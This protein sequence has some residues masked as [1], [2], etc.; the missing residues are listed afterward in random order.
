[1]PA[2][3]SRT[4]LEAKK[5]AELQSLA[6][7]HNI[8]ANLKTDELV[9]E[10]QKAMEKLKKSGPSTT[11]TTTARRV[12]SASE[13]SSGR[14]R[15]V[16]G[17]SKI[18][19]PSIST[20]SKSVARSKPGGFSV[21]SKGSIV[22]SDEEVPPK[23][24][25]RRQAS[26]KPSNSTTSR[27]AGTSSRTRRTPASVSGG[28]KGKATEKEEQGRP[29]SSKD[30]SASRQSLGSA[31]V[32]VEIPSRRTSVNH[33]G[34]GASPQTTSK[35]LESQS[36]STQGPVASTSQTG[37]QPINRPSIISAPFFA[38]P[39][40]PTT[41]SKS[42]STSTLLETLKGSEEFRGIAL[43]T[44]ASKVAI[45][46]LTESLRLERERT[47]QLREE[48]EAVR[49]G[50]DAALDD[51]K[52]LREDFL[53]FRRVGETSTRQTE[54][55][56]ES[57]K[58]TVHAL[59]AYARGL[60]GR[61]KTLE[62]DKENVEGTLPP[63]APLNLG[64]RDRE[65]TPQR[66]RGDEEIA[67]SPSGQPSPT[68]RAR[69][70]EPSQEEPP[71]QRSVIEE[72]PEESASTDI[73][74]TGEIAPAPA[75]QEEPQTTIAGTNGKPALLSLGRPS[76]PPVV[77]DEPPQS[78]PITAYFSSLVPPPN[79]QHPPS[80][81]IPKESLV[82]LPSSSAE[83]IQPPLSALPF[84]LI[85]SK[86]LTTG[87]SLGSGSNGLKSSRKDGSSGR[88]NPIA[89]R[90]PRGSTAVSKADSSVSPA[91][92]GNTGAVSFGYSVGSPS[93]SSTPRSTGE[94]SSRDDDG[95]N[96]SVTL[97]P[98]K[99]SSAPSLGTLPMPRSNPFR[100]PSFE[101]AP[102]LINTAPSTS[103]TRAS[104]PTSTSNA[105]LSPA[106]SIDNAPRGYDEVGDFGFQEESYMSLDSPPPPSP[107]KR[108]MY[109]TEIHPPIT[110]SSSFGAGATGST[111]GPFSLFGSVARTGTSSISAG[112]AFRGGSLPPFGATGSSSSNGGLP[113]APEPRIAELPP[114]DEDG[115]PERE[116]D[117]AFQQTETTGDGEMRRNPRANYGLDDPL[118][119]GSPKRPSS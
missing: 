23:R 69:T 89:R 93:A 81:Q 7:E 60:E 15:V 59:D 103:P 9:I 115:G 12:P 36:V 94:V 64:K 72:P 41:P 63:P 110:Q 108:T 19:G 86:P 77:N 8:K 11:T 73:N 40:A 20:S 52:T 13:S 92:V 61:V 84:P 16:P 48:L 98:P 85:P 91:N 2:V 107:S 26:A 51:L 17:T 75:T 57:L 43:D 112:N 113:R 33:T 74:P 100:A 39:A 114:V 50:K 88:Y 76:G 55:L 45:N 80:P 18:P 105:P 5:R 79:Y 82:P 106:F 119:W 10:L 53:E 87:T 46:S 101:F 99:M 31:G 37:P 109:G 56:I 116:N 6:K 78:S 97:S 90:T 66:S 111:G 96:D 70:T 22:S 118:T 49:K 83:L 32:I 28:G 42:S 58:A 38:V 25:A 68:K 21:K 67:P 35:Q 24:P 65:G 117:A 102:Q 44:E 30:T 1:M 47:A 4:Q 62:D 54:G 71:E 29:P 14:P 27:P 3:F 104:N 95:G 34:S